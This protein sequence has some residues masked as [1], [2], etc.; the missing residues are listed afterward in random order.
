MK[1]KKDFFQEL[2]DR[3]VWREVRAYLLSGAAGIPFL[4]G[5]HSLYPN[6][7]P[8]NAVTI[9]CI[10]FF[11]LFPSVFLFAYHHGESREA[12]WSK[13]EKRWIPTNIVLTSFLLIFFYNNNVTAVETTTKLVENLAT[14][15]FVERDVVK[16][17]FRKKLM[18]TYFKNESGDTSLNWLEHGFPYG[19]DIDLEQDIYISSYQID[20]WTLE[21]LGFKY[22][23]NIPM[24]SYLQA[25]RKSGE[26]NVLTGSFTNINNKFKVRFSIWDSKKGRKISEEKELIS[27]D[28]FEIMDQITISIKSIL[29]DNKEY[30]AEAVDFTVSSQLTE[31]FKAYK[32]FIL[33]KEYDL[34]FN[35]EKTDNNTAQ[36]R[37]NLL[38]KAIKI[39]PHFVWAY[40]YSVNLYSN[41]NHQDSVEVSWKKVIKKLGQLTIGRQYQAR[42]RW[43]SWQ[44]MHEKA[45]KIYED[46]IVFSPDNLDPY[47]SLAWICNWEEEYEKALEYYKQILRIDSN[48]DINYRLTAIYKQMGDFKHVIKYK[49]KEMKNYPEEASHAAGIA[50]TFQYLR[51]IDS[52]TYYFQ[53]AIDKD[54][55]VYWYHSA[56]AEY[57]LNQTMDLNKRKEI[58]LSLYEFTEDKDDTLS[59]GHK[60]ASEQQR[61]GKI[62]RYYEMTDSLRKLT[63][64]TRRDRWGSKELQSLND[65]TKN[66]QRHVS[67]NDE[68]EILKIIQIVTNE[69]Y[70]SNPEKIPEELKKDENYPEYSDFI[71]G[72]IADE[73]YNI[74]SNLYLDEYYHKEKF[75][76]DMTSFLEYENM[77]KP[78]TKFFAWKNVKPYRIQAQT[79]AL[80]N[81][82]DSAITLLEKHK[83]DI[84]WGN[85]IIQLARYYQ[86]NKDYAKAEENFK[87][88]LKESPFSP[89]HNYRVAL[90][91]NDWGKKEKA[92]KHLNITLEIWKD[93]DED[94]FYSNM[95]KATAQKWNIEIL[96]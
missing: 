30:V 88:L 12:P 23:D 49:K 96:N 76:E 95:A 27:E 4:I 9:V 13:A 77:H 22:G 43:Y 14:G 8:E 32:Y 41:L 2:R 1:K 87:I 35:S 45:K 11:T 57:K 69:F 48:A 90:L 75:K 39:D 5:L 86:K 6:I 64:G 58:I 68:K 17:E 91:Y 83:T 31:S 40:Y 70:F 89:W 50:R 29:L 80:N 10:I 63:E 82:Y 26:E 44:D 62:N 7:L 81:Q 36:E 53:K 94:S 54:P 21:R 34:I 25:A 67:R 79:F 42:A 85:Y 19:I 38:Q 18:T 72:L 73:Y 92:E 3:N 20:N 74:M 93:A 66:L 37:V 59:I 16:P 65:S 71:K 24:A 51:E 84:S 28:I 47:R 60:I 55:F 15:E 52:A 56:L 46:W 33:S 78:S 61:Q